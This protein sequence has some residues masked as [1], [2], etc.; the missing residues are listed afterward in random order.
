LAPSDVRVL[1][2]FSSRKIPCLLQKIF[3]Q[4]SRTRISQGINEVELLSSTIAGRRAGPGLSEALAYREGA[5]IVSATG[6][7]H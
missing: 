3:S 4:L 6:D 7:G 2:I 1:Y 5:G